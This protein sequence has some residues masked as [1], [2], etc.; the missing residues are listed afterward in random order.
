VVSRGRKEPLPEDD[1]DA[2]GEA[3]IV[4]VAELVRVV[5]EVLEP[6]PEAVAV[7][8]IVLVAEL[9]RVVVDVLVAEAVGV[10]VCEELALNKAEIITAGEYCPAVEPTSNWP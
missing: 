1:A 5:V 2:E 10:L 9:V 6:V 7:A 3:V 8:V 4:L